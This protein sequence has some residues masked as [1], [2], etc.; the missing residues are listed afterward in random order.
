M[1][2]WMLSPGAKHD[3]MVL[4]TGAASP[5][6]TLF[7]CTFSGPSPFVSEVPKQPKVS[8]P[9]LEEDITNTPSTPMVLVLSPRPVWALLGQ[10]G[11]A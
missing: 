9:P 1:S 6:V 3:K 2:S 7:L 11:V 4:T 5:L 8:S 10:S